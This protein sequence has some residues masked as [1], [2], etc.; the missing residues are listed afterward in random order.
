RGRGPALARSNVMGLSSW[1]RKRN[2]SSRSPRLRAAFR[3]RLEA[4]EDRWLPTTLHV[5]S[6]LDTGWAGDGSLRGEIAAAQSGDTIDFNIPTT[7]RGYNS[8]TG[9]WTISLGAGELQ[10]A[11]SLTIQGPG[12]GQVTISGSNDYYGYYGSRIFEVDGSTTTV[13][14]SGLS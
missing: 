6:T 5:T 11:K 7:D 2:P 8:S 12:A 4:L 13:N 14:L 1:L 9:I 10:I 3:P